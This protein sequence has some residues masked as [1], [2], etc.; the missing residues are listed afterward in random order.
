MPGEFD[1]KP[2]ECKEFHVSITPERMK[3]MT[4]WDAAQKY[5][6]SGSHQQRPVRTPIELLKSAKS[7]IEKFTGDMSTKHVKTTTEHELGKVST[8]SGKE[9]ESASRLERPPSFAISGCAANRHIHTNSGLPP[10]C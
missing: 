8:V 6:G 9:V 4:D 3:A 5:Y 1:L 7:I 2:E 10:Y